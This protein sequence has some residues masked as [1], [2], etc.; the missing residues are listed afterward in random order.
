MR[1]E[2]GVGR[3]VEEG[4][5]GRVVYEGGDG[6]VVYKGGVEEKNTSFAFA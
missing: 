3:V 5:D 6:R 4:G 1:S 2:G